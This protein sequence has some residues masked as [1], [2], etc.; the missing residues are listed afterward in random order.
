MNTDLAADLADGLGH[1]EGVITALNR[2]WAANESQRQLFANFD[3][4]DFV[5]FAVAKFDY[6]VNHEKHPV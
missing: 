5:D 6:I 2:T 4:V 3:F 1:H